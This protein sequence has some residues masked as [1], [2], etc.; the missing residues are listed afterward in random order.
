MV[1]GYM[2]PFTLLVLYQVVR[3][4]ALLILFYKFLGRDRDILNYKNTLLAYIL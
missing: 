2:A 3:W 4:A 1:T